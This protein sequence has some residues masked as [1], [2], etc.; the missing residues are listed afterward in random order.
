VILNGCQAGKHFSG[1][2][3]QGKPLAKGWFKVPKIEA[4]KHDE[5]DKQSQQKVDDG[6]WVMLEAMVHS[7]VG[8]Q[9]V[10]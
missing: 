9:G 3:N 7:P 10:E 8:N 6:L 2:G 1:Q 4:L 5:G